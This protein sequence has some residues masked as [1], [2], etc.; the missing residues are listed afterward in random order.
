MA[1]STSDWFVCDVNTL[2]WVFASPPISDCFAPVASVCFGLAT[3]RPLKECPLPRIFSRFPDRSFGVGLLLLRVAVGSAAALGGSAGL[4]ATTSLI[5]EAGL[6][7]GVT[8]IAG[9][10]LLLGLLTPIMSV[11][12]FIGYE[13]VTRLPQNSSAGHALSPW[14]EVLLALMVAFGIA[15][16]G[17]GAY[18]LDARLFGRRRVIIPRVPRPD[19][20]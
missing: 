12:A 4:S 5:S 10:C 20:E 1:L 17:P 14:L 6:I 7:N 9:V 2:I 13:V 19:G 8:A 16:V 3:V 18:S 11:L 15:L